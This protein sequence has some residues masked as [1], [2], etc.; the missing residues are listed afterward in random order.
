MMLGRDKH[1]RMVRGQLF[2]LPTMINCG[3]F[4]EFVREFYDEEL[5]DHQLRE[6]RR[7]LRVC[8]EC[9]VYLAAYRTTVNLGRSAFATDS[10][11]S[12]PAT[13]PADLIRAILTARSS[14]PEGSV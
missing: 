8:P 7:H 10:E 9:R 2:R 11:S 13:V 1:S 12:I 14:S 6:F 3:E 4:E 5:P